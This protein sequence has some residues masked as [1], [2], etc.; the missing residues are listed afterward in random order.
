MIKKIENVSFKQT[1]D[2]LSLFPIPSGSHTDFY[3]S[4]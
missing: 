4:S 3:V 1:T 2:G